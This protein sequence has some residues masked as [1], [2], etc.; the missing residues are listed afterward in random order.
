MPTVTLTSG[1]DSWS[2][3]LAGQYSVIGLAGNDVITVLTSKIRETASGTDTL[4]GGDGNDK[5][6]ASFTNDSLVGGAGNDYLNGG[7]G[8]DILDGGNDDDTLLGGFGNDTLNGGA[9][10]DM[11]TTSSGNHLVDGG[12]GNDSIYANSGTDTVTAGDGNDYVTLG[13]GNDTGNGGAG[14]DSMLGGAGDDTV[15]GGAGD[16]TLD[17]GENGA[18]GDTASYE[19][20]LAGVTVDLSRTDAQNTGGAGIDTLTGF[21]ILK[22]SAFN[23]VLSGDA[24]NNVLDGGNGNDTLDGGDGADQLLGQGGI[25]VADYTKS[26]AA[27]GI[28]LADGL[29]ETGGFAEGDI[30]GTTTEVIWGSAFDDSL[31]G[32]GNANQLEGR[33][34]NDAI[35]GGGGND[36]LFGGIGNDIVSGDD[37]NDSLQ[38]GAGSDQLNGGAGSDL[39][40]YSDSTAAVSINLADGLAE[41][42]GFADGDLL[43]NIEA[44][45]G[46]SF[47]DTLIGDAAVNTLFG[48]LG[49]DTITGGAGQDRLYATTSLATS[50]ASDVFDYNATAELN[51]F[52]I[53][54]GFTGGSGSGFD[55]IDLIDLFDSLSLS[56]AGSTPQEQAVNA[57]NQGYWGVRGVSFNDGT[58][59]AANSALYYIDTNGGFGATDGGEINVAVTYNMLTVS[60]SFNLLV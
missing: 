7:E 10:A 51:S 33:D 2:T 8:D 49:N 28:N 40:I 36:A 6:T 17:G 31:T 3:T 23:D 14:T 18:G 12:G 43:S 55:K 29:A 4:D 9:G 15:D 46:S 20:A 27:V 1:N 52:D 21:E 39:A 38:G 45:L 25:D 59:G 13:G 26:T 42:G 41:T 37:G 5:L 22:G 30:I 56:F 48:N 16:D 34:G 19:S 54:Y 24:T 35:S 11:I 58:N 44:I 32:N 53:I 57:Y 60:T 47:G 50:T